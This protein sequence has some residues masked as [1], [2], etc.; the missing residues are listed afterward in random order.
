[1]TRTITAESVVDAPVHTVFERWARIED[2]PQFMSMVEKVTPVGAG[3][4][5]WTVSIGGVRREFDARVTEAEHDDHI[6]WHSEGEKIHDGVV[7]FTDLGPGRTRVSLR[8]DWEPAS[9]TERAGAL[10][11][12]DENAVAEDLLRFTDMV[13]GGSDDDVRGVDP[14]IVV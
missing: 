8:M 10:L 3:V 13:E 12:I 11:S 6:A 14:D 4:T 9:F 7:R 2:F 5:H 1:M